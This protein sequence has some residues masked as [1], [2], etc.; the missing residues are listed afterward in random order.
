MWL[1]LRKQEIKKTSCK[2]SNLER[3]QLVFTAISLGRMGPNP[4]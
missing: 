4:V 2:I 3:K 1:N